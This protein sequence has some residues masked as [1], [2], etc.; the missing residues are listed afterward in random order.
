[1]VFDATTLLRIWTEQ[2]PRTIFP[3]RRVGFLREGYEASFVALDANP[4]ADFAAVRKVA[5]RFKQGHLIK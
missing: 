1:G 4:L 2:T 3:A 5:L